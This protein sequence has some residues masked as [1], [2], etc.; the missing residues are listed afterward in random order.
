MPGD[1]LNRARWCR[2]WEKQ[3]ASYDQRMGFFDRVLLGGSRAW[4]CAQATGRVCTFSLAA[5]EGLESW[6]QQQES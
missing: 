4:V 1:Q 2:F 5:C 6:Q 3:S